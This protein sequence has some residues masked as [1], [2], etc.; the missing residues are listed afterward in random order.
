MN[1]SLILNRI[2][3]HYNFKSDAEFARF[4]KISPQVLANWHRRNS[5]DYDVLYTRCEDIDP[6]WL[7]SGK[8]PMLKDRDTDFDNSSD[9][10]IHK[11]EE[12]REKLIEMDRAIQEEVDR[13]TKLIESFH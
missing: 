8:E 2:K 9:S 4:L 11:L 13:L 1:K 3:E 10:L 12:S 7:F 5:F 6:N